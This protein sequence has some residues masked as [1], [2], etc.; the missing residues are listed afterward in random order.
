VAVSVP[1]TLQTQFNWNLA[2]KQVSLST[3]TSQGRTM[4]RVR[5]AG[6]S[7]QAWA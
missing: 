2:L 1:V 3:V 4:M 5:G 7:V 6:N